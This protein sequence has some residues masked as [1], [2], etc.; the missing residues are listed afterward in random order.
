MKKIMKLKFLNS[1]IQNK[2]KLSN[3]KKVKK[4]LEKK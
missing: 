3:G 2:V 1:N 4:L